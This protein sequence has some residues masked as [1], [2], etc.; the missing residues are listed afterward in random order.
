MTDIQL[1]VGA[2][3]LIT[4][5]FFVGAEF[6]L[7]SVRRSQIE[8]RAQAGEKRARTVLWGLRHLSAAMATA[9]LGITV[10]SLVLGAVAEPAIAHLLEPGFEA[11]GVPAGLTHP[12]AFVIALTVATYLH[13]LIGEMVPKNIA[14][15]APARTALA[16][17]PALIGLTRALR[18]VVFGINAFANVLLRLLRV[19]PKDE[20]ESVF[21]DD[22]LIGLVMASS[23][24]GL[25]DRDDGE[26]L[27]DAL[28]LGNRP[29]GEVMVPLDRMVT[30]GHQV[31]PREL[32]R[33]AAA[34]RYSRL[35]V[36][37]PGDTVLGYLHIK[38]ALGVTAREEPFPR[39]ALHT[40]TPVEI[41]TPLDDALTVM[42]AAG[43][44][45]AAVTGEKGTVLGF[46]TMDDVLGELVGPPA[47]ES[48]DP[49]VL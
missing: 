22:E 38:D 24:A 33:A 31:T 36:T 19:E 9:Q 47:A 10:S 26:R 27:R 15:A 25:L 42:R 8:P 6:A 40:I 14:L 49:A 4:N 30:V 13:M 48:P 28:E 7:I 20:V 1:V 34:S 2:L 23:A 18:P 44:H 11:I 5:A 45:L 43:T 37:G 32:E 46:V 16:L 35:P 41:D 21:T 12:I 29:V 17:G 39:E 3:T